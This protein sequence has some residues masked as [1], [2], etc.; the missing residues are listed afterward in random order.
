MLVHVIAHPVAGVIERIATEMGSEP[1]ATTIY[2][3]LQAL[4]WLMLWPFACH[5][6]QQFR[7]LRTGFAS[8]LL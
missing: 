7:F 6:T 4:H 1:G 8:D 3:A 2:I 5:F